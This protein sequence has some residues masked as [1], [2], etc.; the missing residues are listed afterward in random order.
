MSELISGSEWQLKR[1]NGDPFEPVRSPVP[2]VIQE[3]RD[4][5]VRYDIGTVLNQRKPV[6]VF[7]ELYE[8]CPL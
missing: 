2:A 7:L 4:D 1:E 6:S 3:I 8:P 5:W